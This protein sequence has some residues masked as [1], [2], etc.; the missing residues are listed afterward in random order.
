MVS[1]SGARLTLN[2]VQSRLLIL[3][4]EVL[5]PLAHNQS[6]LNLIVQVDAPRPDHGALARKKNGRGRLLE[7]EGLLRPRA[8]ELG[9]VVPGIQVSQFISSQFRPENRAIGLGMKGGY[10]RIVAAN[11]HD[12]AGSL[13]RC[14]SS[15]SSSYEHHCE[16][17]PRV[18]DGSLL[19]GR[20]GGISALCVPILW[21]TRTRMARFA[22][23]LRPIP[24]IAVGS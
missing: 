16:Q 8:V 9:D 20:L 4:I 24:S 14:H 18:G 12:L 21:V 1:Q 2:C 17:L 23:E 7:K 3:R 15:H 10:S 13:Q 11:A 22:E 6:E 19:F 5:Q